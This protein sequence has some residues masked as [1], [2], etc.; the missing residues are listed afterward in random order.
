MTSQV[1][2]FFIHGKKWGCFLFDS[3]HF[4]N[5]DKCHFD[6]WQMSLGN[7][8]TE[9]FVFWHVSLLNFD[10]CHFWNLT[11]ARCNFWYLT[12]VTNLTTATFETWQLSL[13]TFDIS[14]QITSTISSSVLKNLNELLIRHNFT[15]F[16]NFDIYH[17]WIL[18]AV[19]LEIWQLSLLVLD[20]CN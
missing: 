14:L 9:H 11:D 12:D 6:I 2:P 3:C 8:T 17:F 15:L 4:W 20:R 10:S 16:F 1:V 19:I 5:F 7:L 13:L 18:T